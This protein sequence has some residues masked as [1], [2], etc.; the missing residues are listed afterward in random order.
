MPITAADIVTRAFRRLGIKAEDENLS[1]DQA[2]HGLDVLNALMHGWRL[3]GIN[4]V[5]SDMRATDEF[6]AGDEFIGPTVSLLAAEL[7][8][9]YNAAVTWN[10]EADRRRL[11][12]GFPVLTVPKMSFDQALMRRSPSDGFD[13]V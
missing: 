4:Y 2:D 7:A 11:Q 5:H 1:A 12:I 9:D 8:P 6:A 10:V 13:V 3:D